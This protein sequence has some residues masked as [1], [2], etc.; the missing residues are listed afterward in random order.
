[1]HR[2]Q[3]PGALQLVLLRYAQRRAPSHPFHSEGPRLLT[4][5]ASA[6]AGA[7]RAC[8]PLGRSRWP[9]VGAPL[10]LQ[11]HAQAHRPQDVNQTPK[12]TGAKLSRSSAHSSAYTQHRP[13]CG[14]LLSYRHAPS[15]SSEGLFFP[16]QSPRKSR[17]LLSAHRIPAGLQ[18]SPSPVAAPVPGPWPPPADR[19]P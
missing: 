14:P 13:A 1:M 15:M 4:T 11:K 10:L 9:R 17:P 12:W 6:Q 19:R 16:A 5:R 7:A 18:D 3:L 8:S 2:P